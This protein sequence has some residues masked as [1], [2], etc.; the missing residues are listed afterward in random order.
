MLMAATTEA[1]PTGSLSEEPTGP[2]T[3]A[4]APCPALAWKRETPSGECS[5]GEIDVV[6]LHGSEKSV[7]RCMV[8]G[9]FLALKMGIQEATG[10]SNGHQR[11]IFDKK[12]RRDAESFEAAGVQHNSKVR[13]MYSDTFHMTSD[14][15][16]SMKAVD[17]E[18]A[19]LEEEIPKAVKKA[20]QR[21]IDYATIMVQLASYEDLV[22]RLGQD[23]SNAYKGDAASVSMREGLQIRLEDL[24]KYIARL[25]A[26]S[27]AHLGGANLMPK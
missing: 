5:E 13:V 12:Q 24:R 20:E 26:G 1:A 16:A 9:N 18:V 3:A 25:R 2:Q 19:S 11:L 15:K 21:L 10:L 22:T 17:E 4:P 8:D 14:G 7:V 6:V 27:L 23:L